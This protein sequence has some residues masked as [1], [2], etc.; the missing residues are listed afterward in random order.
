[1]APHGLINPTSFSEILLVLILSK[2]GERGGKGMRNEEL[3]PLFSAENLVL[4]GW[5]LP[6][7]GHVPLQ[8]SRSVIA[9][10]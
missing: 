3:R 6:A 1:M 7:T 10:V 5:S 9:S 8:V 2:K 4:E